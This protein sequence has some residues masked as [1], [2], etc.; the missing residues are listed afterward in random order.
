MI[1]TDVP[2][3]LD[4]AVVLATASA[5]DGQIGHDYE[6]GN[7]VPIDYYVIAQYLADAPRAYLFAV[8]GKHEVVADT[9]WDSATEA[10]E[11]ARSSGYVIKEF[12]LRRTPG[13]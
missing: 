13:K 9:L 8:S 2:A 10:A 6:T 4:G 7:P 5:L 1:E 3:T 12:Q 11:A